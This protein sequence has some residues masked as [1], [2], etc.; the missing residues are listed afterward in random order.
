MSA[1]LAI[2]VSAPEFAAIG[3]ADQIG[4]HGHV[5]A[6]LDDAPQEKGFD[7]EGLA[8]LLRIVFFA[9]VAEDGAAREDF[10]VG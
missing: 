3:G 5:V 2:V 1:S 4:L 10:E 9:F 6:M 8:D 7:F